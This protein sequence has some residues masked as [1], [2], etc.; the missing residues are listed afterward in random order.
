MKL[1]II[2]TTHNNRGLLRQLLKGL[3]RFP[4]TAQH[5]M[6]VVD[7]HSTDKTNELIATEFPQVTYIRNEVNQGLAKANNQGIKK[8]T[9]EYLL[10]LNPDIAVFEGEIDKLIA[11][12]ES[13]PNAGLVG[14][15]LLHP[16][17]TVQLSTY[18]FPKWYIPIL[19]RTPLGNLPWAKKQLQAYLMKDWNH[20]KTQKVDWVLGA[21]MLIRRSALD[22]VGLQDEDYFLYFED[23][24]WCKR[25]WDAGYEVWY[26]ANSYFVHYHKRESAE[27]PGLQGV[28]QP[29]TKVHI[30]SWLTYFKKHPATKS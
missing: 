5:E 8:S 29:L 18:I 23:V 21:V 15:K 17:K 25:F 13:H 30:K 26:D 7:N 11:C 20:A 6:I 14:P 10:I 28:F 9:G 16:D 22:K 4:P 3:F 27:S 2:I 19:R 12:L 24:D 1:S